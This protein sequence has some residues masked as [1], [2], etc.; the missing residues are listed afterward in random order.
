VARNLARDEERVARG[1]ARHLELIRAERS[2]DIDPG[3]EPDLLRAE[4]VGRVRRTLLRLPERDQILLLMH[5]A[6]FRYRELAQ[7]LR[8][9][10]TSVGPLLT[11]AQRRFIASYE[12][13]SQSNERQASA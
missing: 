11:R 8:L 9:A 7:T 4:N 13:E 6:G 2:D 12:Q 3:P 10:P 5:H 1:R